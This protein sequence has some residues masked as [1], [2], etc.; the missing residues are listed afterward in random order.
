M[1]VEDMF[2]TMAYFILCQKVAN[3]VLRTKKKILT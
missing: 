3:V 1:V 2:S